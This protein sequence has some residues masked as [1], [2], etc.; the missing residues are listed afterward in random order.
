MDEAPFTDD[1]EVASVKTREELAVFLRELH[2]RA[3]SPS[4]RSLERWAQKEGKPPLSKSTLSDVLS[5]RRFPRKSVLLTFVEA[6]G[7]PRDQMDPWRRGWE[8]IAASERQRPPPEAESIELDR[9]RSKGAEAWGAAAQA[10]AYQLGE[11][12]RT[13]KSQPEEHA[14]EQL[15][16]IRAAL[17]LLLEQAEK[18]LRKFGVDQTWPTP[19]ETYELAEQLVEG[20]GRLARLAGLPSEQDPTPLDKLLTLPQV[21]LIVD[22]YNVTKNTKMG[23]GELPLADQRNRLLSGL[24]GLASQTRAE[25]TCVF[26]GAE[27]DAPVALSAPR[28]V[29]VLFSPPGETA[30]KLIE[31]LVRTEPE[32]RAVVVVSSDRE[33]A[34]LAGARSV[35][36]TLLLRRLRHS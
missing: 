32:G 3:D 29:R 30:D 21:H 28:G 22:G 2:A 33:V 12:D 18:G 6:C 14:D 4:L 7:V 23:Y 34:P 25:I 26:D 24:G 13:A 20:I 31:R 10:L 15:K 19:I 35:P 16:D 11:R 1:L 8:R 5:G 9:R 36:S 17:R 27:L